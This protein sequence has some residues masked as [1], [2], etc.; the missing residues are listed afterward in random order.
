M[1]QKILVDV[2]RISEQPWNPQKPW[3]VP[4]VVEHGSHVRVDICFSLR[5]TLAHNGRRG[6]GS[7]VAMSV[8][9]M[10]DAQYSPAKI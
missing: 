2:V 10:T 6:K 3:P 8:A 4:V 5:C 7:P 1:R 9:K